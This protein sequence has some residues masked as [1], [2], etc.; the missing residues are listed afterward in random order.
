MKSHSCTRM[1]II[2]QEQ[3]KELENQFLLGKYQQCN[4]R[5][6]LIR[7]AKYMLFNKLIS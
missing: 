4:S 7:V 6:V 1:K 3:F 2:Q 5:N